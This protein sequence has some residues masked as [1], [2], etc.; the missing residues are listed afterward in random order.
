MKTLPPGQAYVLS[1]YADAEDEGRQASRAEIAEFCGYAFP[2]AV[3]KHVDALVRKGLLI[4]EPD[5]KRN[6][7]LSDEGWAALNRSPANLGVPIL[8]AIAAGAPIL[9]AENLTGYLDDV[10]AKPGRIALQVRGDSMIEAGINDGDYAVIDTDKQA[11][12]GSIAAVLVDEETTL[13]VI[14]Q[15]RG[16]LVLEPR[17]RRLK[18]LVLNKAAQTENGVRI[19]GPLAFIV[20]RDFT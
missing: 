15:R 5:K 13:K 19:I 14:R 7:R 11:A 3:T 17:N 12:D 1:C 6:I 18:P 8:G 10:S 9:A 4:S 16:E 2:S 20:R